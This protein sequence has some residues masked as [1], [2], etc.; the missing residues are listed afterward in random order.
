MTAFEFNKTDT[1]PLPIKTYIEYGLDKV[2][3][4]EEQIDPLAQLLEIMGSLG[5]KEQLWLQF[6]VRVHKKD[7][8]FEIGKSWKD[9]AKA[10]IQKVRA[11]AVTETEQI[12]AAGNV[13]KIKGGINPT[14]GQKS[15]IKAIEQNIGKQPYDVGI[16][17]IYC[18]PA[19]AAH[20]A[21]GG[22]LAN[23]FKP[24]NSEQYNSLMPNGR[25][26]DHFN[27]Y[28]WE[29][30]G[31]HHYAQAMRD[32]LHC[33]RTRA[34]FHPFYIGPY[35]V[36]STEEMATLYHVPSS[37][38]TTPSLPRIQSTTSEAPSNLPT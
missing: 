36:M 1:D 33:Y 28:P 19:D 20:R 6:V 7:G 21:M 14:E 18:A 35:N 29:D 4:P 24:F 25:W 8:K 26:S 23:L 5:P 11:E 38:V 22:I 15:R 10:E 37:S 3:K 2:Q 12:D 27:E 34:F 16:R 17:G 31:G 9:I 30:K 32:A 13:K